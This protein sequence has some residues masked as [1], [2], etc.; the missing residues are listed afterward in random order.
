MGFFEGR[1]ILCFTHLSWMKIFIVFSF[2][3]Y[4]SHTT[5]YPFNWP[6]AIR[7]CTHRAESLRRDE[8]RAGLQLIN[9]FI[10]R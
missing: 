8:A 6:N 3:W 5:L 10:Y 2:S 1:S 9:L 4:D 7:K